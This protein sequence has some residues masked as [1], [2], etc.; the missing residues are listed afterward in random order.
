MKGRVQRFTSFRTIGETEVTDAHESRYGGAQ[1]LREFLPA[2][3]SAYQRS[4]TWG[5]H[6]RTSQTMSLKIAYIPEANMRR[7][8]S[9]LTSIASKTS[10]AYS[11]TQLNDSS[12]MAPRP[13][14]EQHRLR[15][16][17]EHQQLQLPDLLSTSASLALSQ[18]CRVA[19]RKS[20]RG[21]RA[22]AAQFQLE[23]KISCQGDETVNSDLIRTAIACY[24]RSK[25]LNYQSRLT[26]SAARNEARSCSVSDA[27]LAAIATSV[28]RFKR[29]ICEK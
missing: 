27:G 15:R 18:N 20:S 9:L 11:E 4:Q 17:H 24:V 19:L 10:A 22:V 14:L 6:F 21:N 26:F 16:H 3:A 5:L 13:L 12:T 7:T 23:T 25:S 28:N 8:P 29:D 2:R 1:T